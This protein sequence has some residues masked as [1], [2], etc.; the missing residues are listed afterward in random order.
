M[1]HE[2]DSIVRAEASED[3]NKHLNRREYVKAS[4]AVAGIVVGSGTGL[5]DL[6]S[7]DGTGETFG[8]GFGEYTS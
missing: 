7:A 8:T 6:T 4:V 1:A 2:L 3:S 5:S